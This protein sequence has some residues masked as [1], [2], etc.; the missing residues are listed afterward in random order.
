MKLRSL[1]EVALMRIN[2]IAVSVE[3]EVHHALNAVIAVIILRRVQNGK[4]ERSLILNNPTV[5]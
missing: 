5:F 4:P 1:G 3:T 2:G